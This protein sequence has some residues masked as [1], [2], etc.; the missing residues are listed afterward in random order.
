M[1]AW[2]P[3][4]LADELR[5][6]AVDAWVE[7]TG[8]AIL[9]ELPELAQHPDVVDVLTEAV[10]EHWLA[11]LAA[12]ARPDFEFH[13][14]DAAA[15][16]AREVAAHQ[17]PVES[18]VKVYQAAQQESWTYVTTVVRSIPSDDI[19]HAAVLIYLWTRAGTWLDQSVGASIEIYHQ[20]RNR[21]VRRVSVQQYEVVQELLNGEPADLR[22]TSAALGGYP[23]S[24]LHTAVVLDSEDGEAVGELEG[25]AQDAARALGA[26][27]PLVVH[28]GG[29]QLWAW[30]ATRER[31][32]VDGLDDLAPA[33]ASAGAHL[34][35]GVP[36]HGPD[37]FVSSHQEAEQ[38]RRLAHDGTTWGRVMRYEEVE[39]LAL[40]GRGPDVDRFV[41]RTLGPLAEPGEPTARLRATVSAFL[42]HGGNVEDAAAELEVHRNTVRYRLARAEELLERPVARAGDEL[43]LAVRHHDLFHCDGQGV[44]SRS[45]RSSSAPGTSA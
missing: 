41:R 42:R 38:A 44:R 3:T 29:R 9:A 24:V 25:I 20:E 17:L 34:F 45:A 12:F 1:S 26:G 6:A 5:P 37:G 22:R 21:R 32:S 39:V 7:R 13:L 2:L 31:P 4:F 8:A 30:F 40:L 35:V 14:V 11:F 27:R 23:L 43:L 15:R 18:L 36:G 10:R 28:P 33:L 16:V 19:D